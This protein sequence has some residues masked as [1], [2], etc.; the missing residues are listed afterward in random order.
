MTAPTP[1]LAPST[2]QILRLGLALGRSEGGRLAR[3]AVRLDKADDD[4]DVWAVGSAWAV[5][6][7]GGVVSTKD[8]PDVMD[9]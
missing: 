2:K 5:E 6:M 1:V 7:E 4:V 8:D 3:L 9:S